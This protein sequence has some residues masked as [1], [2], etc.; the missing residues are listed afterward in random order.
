MFGNNGNSGPLA[1]FFKGAPNV[2]EVATE[3]PKKTSTDTT[4]NFSTDQ[5]KGMASILGFTDGDLDL[6]EVRDE[7]SRVMKS[8]AGHPGSDKNDGNFVDFWDTNGFVKT[9]NKTT[10]AERIA[11]YQQYAF[12]VANSVE[13]GM[14]VRTYIDEILSSI[15]DEDQFFQVEIVDIRTNKTD[16]AATKFINTLMQLSGAFEN[17]RK[18]AAQLCMY[19]DAA[20][21]IEKIV[22][23]APPDD[24]RAVDGWKVEMYLLE[25]PSY[26]SRVNLPT[27][28][29]A[30]KYVERFGGKTSKKVD[31]AP[32]DMIHF[33][34]DTAREDLTPYGE[35]LL[36]I[37]RSSYKRL[38]IIEALLALTRSSRVE[39]IIMK[40]PTNTDN[41]DLMI[42]KLIRYKNIAKNLIF[43]SGSQMTT[44]R[45]P[46]GFTDILYMPK[47]KDKQSSWEMD[48]L[49]GNSVDLGTIDDVEYFQDK[50]TNG[51]NLPR[52]YLKADDAYMGYRKLALQDLRLS[53]TINSVFRAMAEG[54]AMMAKIFM[55]RTENWKDNM[56]VVVK[57]TPPAPVASEQLSAMREALDVIVQIVDT[58]SPKNPETGETVK[59]PKVIRNLLLKL[60]NFPRRMV[61]MIIPPS[62]KLEFEQITT[63]DLKSR[64]Q[65]ALSAST[66]ERVTSEEVHFVNPTKAARRKPENVT[67]AMIE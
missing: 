54:Y 52:G 41:P 5:I 48:R 31:V 16:A 29:V 15:Q 25:K 34:M 67:E 61:D 27:K 37:V 64:L 32:W 59:D 46:I 30:F 39:R 2:A 19:G 38:L 24:P 57:Y 3:A 6:K 12:M 14:A 23:G 20:Q 43:G 33:R 8:G 11:R 21:R 26:F 28:D 66:E 53:R 56:K 36:E 58:T 40:V 7:L 63:E 51:L 10:E 62:E 60:A 4:R 49:Q 55:F 9:P 1:W 13:I 18:R 45:K 22:K 35:S 42:T 47:G 44:D 50:I 65:S 17:P